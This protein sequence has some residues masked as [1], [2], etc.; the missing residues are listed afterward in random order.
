MATRIDTRT[1]QGRRF[2]F[3][4][5]L[6]MIGMMA[7]PFMC[8]ETRGCS[9]SIVLPWSAMSWPAKAGIALFVTGGLAM[10]FAGLRLKILAAIAGLWL[11]VLFAVLLNAIVFGLNTPACGPVI[12]IMRALTEVPVFRDCALWP[13]V[14]ALWI[15][16]FFIGFALEIIRDKHLPEAWRLPLKQWTQGLLLASLAPVLVLMVLLLIPT[17]GASVIQEHWKKW[18]SS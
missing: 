8:H 18:R 11:I 3:I 16:A 10:V 1:P 2:Q 17:I 14:A 7:I 6:A 12:G 15:D 9:L 4:V 13:T 5:G